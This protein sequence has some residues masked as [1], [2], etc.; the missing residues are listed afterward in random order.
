MTALSTMMHT[1]TLAISPAKHHRC[2]TPVSL[3]KF[4]QKAWLC[5]PRNKKSTRYSVSGSRFILD[6]ISHMC[7]S[8]NAGEEVAGKQIPNYHKS[9]FPFHPFDLSLQ[10]CRQ[11]HHAAALLIRPHPGSFKRLSLSSRQTQCRFRALPL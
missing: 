3:A 10:L 5:A 4:M 2:K 11:A 7:L 9:L 8:M 6:V 1:C